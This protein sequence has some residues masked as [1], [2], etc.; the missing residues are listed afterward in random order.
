MSKVSKLGSTGGGHFGQNGQQLH[1]NMLNSEGKGEISQIFGS[2][3]RIPPVFPTPTRGNPDVYIPP[4]TRG[5]LDVHL[6][7]CMHNCLTLV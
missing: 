6:Y 5:N 7:Q 3:G 2:W 4:S 1:E